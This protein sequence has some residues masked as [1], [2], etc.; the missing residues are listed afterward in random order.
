MRSRSL[1]TQAPNKKTPHSENVGSCQL[2]LGCKHCFDCASHVRS[3]RLRQ[4]THFRAQT[5]PTLVRNNEPLLVQRQPVLAAQG[6]FGRL[7][8]ASHLHCFSLVYPEFTRKK[9]LG[10]L[11]RAIGDVD[12]VSVLG[13]VHHQRRP[14]L[15]ARAGCFK[16]FG[17]FAEYDVARD[18][19]EG[20]CSFHDASLG[21]RQHQ[22][23]FALVGY[24]GMQNVFL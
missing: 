21:E 14:D 7:A 5:K 20:K 3:Q 16:C 15:R 11:R 22:R 17:E 9:L 2:K 8:K 19:L 1:K 23:K 13:H 24:P 12:A 4:F 6:K 10:P 18:R